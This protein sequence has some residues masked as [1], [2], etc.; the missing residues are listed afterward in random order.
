[1]LFDILFVC[2]LYLVVTDEVKVK[3]VGKQ[4]AQWINNTPGRSQRRMQGTRNGKKTA[5]P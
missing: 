5:N 1:M 3:N 4:T 2:Y